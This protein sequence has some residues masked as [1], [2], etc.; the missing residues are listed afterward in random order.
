[1][2]TGRG[3]EALGNQGELQEC[4]LLQGGQG[5]P[6]DRGQ[7]HQLCG[8]GRSVSW[9]GGSATSWHGQVLLGQELQS[10]PVKWGNSMCH[11]SLWLSSLCHAPAW[12]QWDFIPG[13]CLYSL[14]PTQLIPLVLPQV[15][16]SE[17][18]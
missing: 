18:R 9:E 8:L 6:G 13:L 15:S 11:P 3:E 4:C 7:G 1:M 16:L 10:L 5:C 14:G 12:N 17:Q 2:V